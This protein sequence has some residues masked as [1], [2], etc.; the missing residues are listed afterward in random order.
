V[1]IIFSKKKK[2]KKRFVIIII[3]YVVIS[4]LFH[5]LYAFILMMLDE[6]FPIES[7]VGLSGVIASN[8][9]KLAIVNFGGVTS[10]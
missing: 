8:S 9:A 1:I 5:L 2:K 3:Y 4:Y 10:V 7:Q 6:Q